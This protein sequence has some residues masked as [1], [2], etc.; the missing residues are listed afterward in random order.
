VEESPSLHRHPTVGTHWNTHVLTA[1]AYSYHV[2][3]QTAHHPHTVCGS[4]H[5]APLAA[6]PGR[7]MC[8]A[9]HVVV[10]EHSARRAVVVDGAL[11]EL[12]VMC[13]LV[14]KVVCV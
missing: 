7:C 3:P 14:G 4:L 13:V 6:C 5:S 2:A 12:D 10:I 9:T 1:R 8:E 11:L